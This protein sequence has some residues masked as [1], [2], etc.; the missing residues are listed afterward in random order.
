M[1]VYILL[2]TC[3]CVVCL[4]FDFKLCFDFHYKQ[5]RWHQDSQF[6]F[7]KLLILFLLCRTGITIFEKLVI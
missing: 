2:C 4:H 5:R 7:N 1:Q 3:L 6:E